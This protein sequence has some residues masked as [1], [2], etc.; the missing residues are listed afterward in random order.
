MFFLC[1]SNCTI[2]ELEPETLNEG[3][4]EQHAEQAH[5]KKKEFRGKEEA[6]GAGD[7]K[8]FFKKHKRLMLSDC[9]LGSSLSYFHSIEHRVLVRELFDLGTPA[10]IYNVCFKQ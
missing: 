3:R 5:N 7:L 1:P 6:L 8:L 4:R 10:T 2:L 9:L